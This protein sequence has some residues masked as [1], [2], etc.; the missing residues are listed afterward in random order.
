MSCRVVTR[1]LVCSGLLSRAGA[2]SCQAV[3]VSSCQVKLHILHHVAAHASS[4]LQNAVAFMKSP[5]FL[6]VLLAIRLVRPELESASPAVSAPFVVNIKPA[7]RNRVRQRA[8]LR[9]LPLAA[10]C[11]SVTVFCSS[12]GACALL[13]ARDISGLTRP[14]RLWTKHDSKQLSAKIL[15]AGM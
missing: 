9:G 4:D 11:G 5:S 15:R 13:D 8:I 7:R 6:G 10:L 1:P 3:K 2:L 14:C 12:G